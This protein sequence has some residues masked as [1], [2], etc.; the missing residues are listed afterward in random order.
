M[1]W[2]NLRASLGTKAYFALSFAF[3]AG[4]V[5][6]IA[7]PQNSLWPLCFWF[8]LWGFPF[9]FSKRRGGTQ[10]MAKLGNAG[11]ETPQRARRGLF[12]AKRVRVKKEEKSAE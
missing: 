12:K 2:K 1:N 7:G 4:G 9:A 6:A 5:A 10:K 8:A 3:T 11:G